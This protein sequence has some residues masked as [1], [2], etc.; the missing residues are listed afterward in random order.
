MRSRLPRVFTL[1]LPLALSSGACGDPIAPEGA[2]RFTP[3]P[4]YRTWWGE[5]ADCAGLKR[6]S[7]E[8]IGWYVIPGVWTFE[9]PVREGT[10]DYGLWVG[11][12]ETRIYLA[13]QVSVIERHVKHE[14]LHALLRTGGHPPEVFGP[15]C[16]L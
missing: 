8:S 12:S 4:I 15:R 3:P 1:A 16:G 13:E 6:T 14:M 5:A 10:Q 11:G 7:F 2:V 9:D